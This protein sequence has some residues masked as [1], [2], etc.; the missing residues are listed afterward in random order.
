MVCWSCTNSTLSLLVNREM[1]VL[2]HKPEPYNRVKAVF[3]AAGHS[4]EGYWFDPSFSKAKAND[5]N[6]KEDRIFDKK[7]FRKNSV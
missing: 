7:L 3:E 6:L 5:R 4:Y 1:D 2:D